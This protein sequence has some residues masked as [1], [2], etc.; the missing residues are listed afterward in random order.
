MPASLRRGRPA[1]LAAECPRCRAQ[2]GARCTSP[3]GRVLADPH[4][5]RLDTTAPKEP[6]P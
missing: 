2:P 5:S 4:P 6:T 3:R 1:Q